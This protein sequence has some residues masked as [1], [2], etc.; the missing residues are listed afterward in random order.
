MWPRKA[1]P[2]NSK[3]VQSATVLVAFAGTGGR[4]VNNRAGNAMKLPPPATAFNAPASTAEVKSSAAFGRVSSG[5]GKFSFG[6]RDVRAPL[7]VISRHFA[8]LAAR[9][10]RL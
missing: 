6:V 7:C 1:P 4:P 10:R 9:D 8:L 5:I 2:L 3:P